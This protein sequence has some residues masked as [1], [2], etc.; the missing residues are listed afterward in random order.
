MIEKIQKL[1]N[2]IINGL[3]PLPTPTEQQ[4]LD[5]LQDSVISQLNKDSYGLKALFLFYQEMTQEKY[6]DFDY[7]GRAIKTVLEDFSEYD[8]MLFEAIMEAQLTDQEKNRIFDAKEKQGQKSDIGFY[9]EVYGI[10]KEN[11]KEACFSKNF[12]L[13]AEWFQL[14]ED[15]HLTEEEKNNIDFIYVEEEKKLISHEKCVSLIYEVLTTSKQDYK[16]IV[17][18]HYRQLENEEKKCKS[19]SKK[20]KT[21]IPPTTRKA[22]KRA[23]DQ[24]RDFI[25]QPL[26]KKQKKHKNSSEKNIKKIEPTKRQKDK[27]ATDQE[28]VFM[29]KPSLKKQKKSKNSSEKPEK[30]KSPALKSN[31]KTANNNNITQTRPTVGGK[32]P[33]NQFVIPVPSQITDNSSKNKQPTS[34]QKPGTTGKKTVPVPI[35]NTNSQ[36]ELDE[37]K[38][39]RL[40]ELLK[41]KPDVPQPKA[42]KK[43]PG[44]NKLAKQ[45]KP[46]QDG[47]ASANY[48]GSSTFF[49]SNSPPYTGITTPYYSYSP[50]SENSGYESPENSPIRSSLL[51]SVNRTPDSPWSPGTVIL[52]PSLPDYSPD[53]PNQ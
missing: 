10:F 2:D 34:S 1:V 31:S 42:P 43:Q 29:V 16:N 13:N 37:L 24:D 18:T 27:R 47:Y 5:K 44:I 9:H 33:R 50:C 22:T 28:R 35:I 48:A 12:P 30:K 11:N 41:K 26:L 38:K 8:C 39:L 14:I 45:K 4:D 25:V 21:T 46:A 36:K 53:R 40:I 15:I 6:H 3:D 51:S 32:A 20:N 49:A 19:S 7:Q 52:T 23:A 17:L